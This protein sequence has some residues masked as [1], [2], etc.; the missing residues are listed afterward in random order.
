LV[1]HFDE[2]LASVGSCF[3]N[4]MDLLSILTNF[5]YLKSEPMLEGVRFSVKSN[6]KFGFGFKNQ[7]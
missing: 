7:A 1:Q 5:A 2:R 4:C 3:G 6:F